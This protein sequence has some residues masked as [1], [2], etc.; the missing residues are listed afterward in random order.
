MAQIERAKSGV[1]RLS[2]SADAQ[3]LSVW[4]VSRQCDRLLCEFWLFCIDPLSFANSHILRL[5]ARPPVCSP[6]WVVGCRSR[7]KDGEQPFEFDGKEILSN[8]SKQAKPKAGEKT[9]TK[10]GKGQSVRWKAWWRQGNIECAVS[11]KYASCWIHQDC[12]VADEQKADLT[13]AAGVSGG[14][15]NVKC[16]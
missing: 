10:G 11:E 5:R 9:D 4:L 12:H 7:K 13:K 15:T 3:V 6:T 1:D 16:D 2:A 8:R 14:K